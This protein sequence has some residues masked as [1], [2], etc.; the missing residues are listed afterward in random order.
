[1]NIQEAIIESIK[2]NK[3]ISR[4]FWHNTALITKKNLNSTIMIIE[5]TGRRSPGKGWQPSYD[6]LIASDWCVTDIDYQNLI[7]EM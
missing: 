7:A 1:M 2:T 5:K 3:A 6:D 4:K